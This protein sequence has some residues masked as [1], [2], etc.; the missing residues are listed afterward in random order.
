MPTITMP[1]PDVGANQL[2]AEFSQGQFEQNL[3]VNVELEPLEPRAFGA[4]FMQGQFMIVPIGWGADYPDPDSWLP[5]NFGS[6]GG[7]NVFGYSNAEFDNLVQQAIAEPDPEER[8][9]L[10][11]QA[12]Q[13]LVDDAAAIFV[14]YNERIILIKPYVENLILTGMDAGVDGEFFLTQT[15]IAQ[16]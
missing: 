15:Y 16:H 10:W 11:D 14:S 9:A 6:T 4:T 12:Q 3:G 2:Y 5:Q 1:F 13:I 7:N 8:L